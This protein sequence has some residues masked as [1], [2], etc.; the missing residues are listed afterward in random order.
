MLA[1]LCTSTAF[2]LALGTAAFGLE[3]NRNSVAYVIDFPL[4][5]GA[6]FTNNGLDRDFYIDGVSGKFRL[7]QDAK[8][9]CTSLVG[10]RA[11]N[12][13]KEG[14][15]VAVR[16]VD[17]L[18]ECALKLSTPDA[19]KFSSSFYSWADGCRC[20]AALHFYYTA[21]DADA[22][23]EIVQ[24]I[25]DAM[26]NGNIRRR[27]QSSTTVA[28][29]ENLY[30]DCDQ[31]RA[32]G[33]TVGSNEYNYC[34]LPVVDEEVPFDWGAQDEEARR[35]AAAQDAQRRAD[36]QRRREEQQ[37]AAADAERRRHTSVF[38]I[39]SED[40]YEVDLE[41]ASQNRNAAWPGGTKVFSITD[42]EWHTYSLSCQPGEKIC[43]GA[44]R[45]GYEYDSYWGAGVD[46]RESCQKCCTTC[47]YDFETTLSPG[48][49]PRPRQTVQAPRGNSIVTSIINGAAI[50]LGIG[51]AIQSGSGYGGGYSG[52]APYTGQNYGTS[53]ISGGN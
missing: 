37:R 28:E 32:R 50:G 4:P 12:K 33:E 23:S 25:L 44:W 19:Q 48:P 40:A 39:R 47:G 27:S 6:E 49:P 3:V 53:G 31:R 35:Q 20:Y 24:S 16:R 51:A 52:G 11:L 18:W 5:G 7:I 43:F 38:R 45:R 21:D 42:H 30:L 26:R 46:V 8:S 15:T 13:A 22:Y 14:Y 1:K 17:G 2:V 34:D 9:D 36:E 10:E 41:F 29:N